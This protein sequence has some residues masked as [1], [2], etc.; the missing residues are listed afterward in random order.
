M[1]LDEKWDLI[2][3]AS[4]PLVM[5]LGNSMLIPILPTIAEKLHV[6]NFEVSMLITV[7]SVVAI[8]LIPIA[9]YLSDLYSC[10]VVIIPSL[11]IVG[12]GGAVSAIAAWL[13]T[14][15]TAYWLMLGGRFLQGIGAAGAAPIVLPLVGDIFKRDTE[16]SKGLSIIETSNTFGKVLSP[17][18]GAALAMMLW[19]LPFV[20]IPVFCLFSL[21]MVIFLVKVPKDLENKVNFKDFLH[22]IGL[23]FREKGRWLY[24]I[25]A[26]GCISMF[27]IFGVLF[28]LSTELEKVYDIKGIIKGLVLAIPLAALCLTAYFTGK[29]IGENKVRMKWVTFVGLLLLTGAIFCIG[30]TEQIYLIISGLVICGIGIGSVLPSLDAMVTEGIEKEHRGTVTSIY[31]SMRFV[32]V[33][34]G[35]PLVSL[36]MS[37]SHKTLFFTVTGVCI[38]GALLALFAIRP[39]KG[40][41]P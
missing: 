9:G 8:F 1:E 16:I 20:A 13:F 3:I 12:I 38:V 37:T 25:F 2:S 36:L 35:P 40:K 26:I 34:L 32:G 10:K 17:I 29:L 27:V 31:S 15:T 23:I 11:I 30:W 18:V 24:A 4:I 19:F 33:A 28:Y 5:T 39:D 41:H 6:T 7:Y 21:L 22:S 14:D